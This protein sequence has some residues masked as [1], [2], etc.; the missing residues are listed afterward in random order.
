MTTTS[1]TSPEWIRLLPDALP[2]PWMIVRRADGQIQHANEL[3]QMM[4]GVDGDAIV[5]RE[6]YD[7]CADA[8]EG[9]M[10]VDELRD[11]GR[12]DEFEVQIKQGDGE[13]VWVGVSASP[14]A[15]DGADAC[16]A[17]VVDIEA[18]RQ[19]EET[20]AEAAAELTD[21]GAFPEMNPGPVLR[22]DRAATVVLANAAA[23]RLFEVRPLEGRAWLE[24]CP[25]M[26][27]ELWDDVLEGSDSVALE[28]QVSDQT[29]VFT[30]THAPDGQY[31]FV[32]GTDLSGERAA[33]R[34][35][36]QSEKMATLGTLA[37]GVAHEM[38]NPAAAAQR[39]AQ[40]LARSI[41][42]L[43]ESWRA[44]ERVGL[45]AD[46][47]ATVSSLESVTHDL[48]ERPV[49]LDA[50]G[51]SNR[52]TELETWLDDRGIEDSWQLAPDL[53]ELE[54]EPV[55]LD[56][57]AD[58]L[59]T[60]QLRCVLAWVARDYE[61]HSL[62]HEIGHGAAR[63]SQIVTALRE[64]SYLDQAPLQPVDLHEG[65]DNTLVILQNK[66][67]AG[68]TVHR[69]YAEDLPLVEAYGSELNQVWTNIIDNAAGAMDGSGDI[70]L[71][72]GV[73]DGLAIVEIEDDGP[74]IP[75]EIQHRVFDAFFTT[76]APGQGTGLGLNTSYNI[77][78]QKHGGEIDMDSEPG[79]TVFTVR[80]PV[81]HVAANGAEPAAS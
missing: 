30:H 34:A 78:V 20:L 15:F 8:D 36:L 19:A 64:Y 53:A 11:A 68:I 58:G 67:K 31:I 59:E 48:V 52:E 46:Q 47:R 65:L 39:A 24:I 71:R 61:V 54:I 1:D 6:M 23:R 3:L 9:A 45:S 76:K 69:D 37:A 51:R 75:E 4:L 42:G 33:E 16:L 63:V 49:Q 32:Y 79:K 60:E 2:V 10:L 38:N 26:T 81:H 21:M 66:L 18:R 73:A 29:F 25:G 70:R 56:Q 80:L 28:S 14:I 41:D 27:D 55:Q 50:I 13:L 74:G 17:T 7:F 22:V 12:T 43:E 77:V 72:T 62:V 35:L 40:Q 5:G 44:L 57:L